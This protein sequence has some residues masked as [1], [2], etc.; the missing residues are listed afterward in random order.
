MAVFCCTPLAVYS[1]ETAEAASSIY[2]K[3][4]P[5]LL[6]V[7]LLVAVLMFISIFMYKNL[8][9]QM[10][11]TILSMVLIATTIVTGFFVIYNAFPGADS[12]SSAVCC[13]SSS[14]LCW[15]SELIA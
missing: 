1:P 11:V 13:C 9:R 2:A 4:A 15:H 12:W 5:V 10:T 6:T 8:K 3:D 14:H 7:A